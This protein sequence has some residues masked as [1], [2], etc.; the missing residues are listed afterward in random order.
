MIDGSE[1]FADEMQL[2]MIFRG[3]PSKVKV[4]KPYKF[5]YTKCAVTDEWVI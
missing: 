3:Q 5:I 4:I 1:L 2:R